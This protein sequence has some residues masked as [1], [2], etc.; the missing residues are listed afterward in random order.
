MA[1][2]RESCSLSPYLFCELI[3][4]KDIDRCSR[5]FLT[6]AGSTSSIEEL[7][8]LVGPKRGRGLWRTYQWMRLS[9]QSLGLNFM[10]EYNRIRGFVLLTLFNGHEV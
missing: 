2:I 4:C 10:S 1:V 9:A 6:I 8:D 3:V 7:Q 5:Q